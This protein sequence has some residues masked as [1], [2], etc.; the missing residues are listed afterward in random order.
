VFTYLGYC[1]LKLIE[2]EVKGNA[3][4]IHNGPQ[5]DGPTKPS[6]RPRYYA[7]PRLPAEIQRKKSILPRNLVLLSVLEN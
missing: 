2:T 5:N 6:S 1:G 3:M 4:A 7:L